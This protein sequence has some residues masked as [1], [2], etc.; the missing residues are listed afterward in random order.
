MQK[1]RDV[2]IDGIKHAKMQ[3]NKPYFAICANN[4]LFLKMPVA[5][6]EPVIEDLQHASAQTEQT[7]YF[8][9]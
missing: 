3:K 4:D 8:A 7:P 5:G 2:S 1:T 6:V 9:V